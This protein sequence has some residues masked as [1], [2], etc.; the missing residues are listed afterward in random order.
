MGPDT[1]DSLKDQ[2]E[3]ETGTILRGMGGEYWTVSARLYN[4]DAKEITHRHDIPHPHNAIDVT[5]EWHRR[6]YEL[7]KLDPRSLGT[8][9]KRL[10]EHDIISHFDLDVTKEEAHEYYRQEAES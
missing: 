10:N 9:K 1:T 6:E 7:A 5:E 8:D 4:F 3:F 2:F